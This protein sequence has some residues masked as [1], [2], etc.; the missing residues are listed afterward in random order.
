VKNK[1]NSLLW[2]HLK[3]KQTKNNSKF[4]FPFPQD[5]LLFW[6]LFISF[7]VRVHTMWNKGFMKMP[8]SSP[9]SWNFSGSLDRK[10]HD[11]LQRVSWK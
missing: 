2:R 5:L 4:C 7:T 10:F 11:L 3:L 8:M 6:D 1:I 9:I